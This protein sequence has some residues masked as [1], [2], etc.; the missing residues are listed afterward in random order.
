MS[1]TMESIANTMSTY[2]NKDTITSTLLFI[3]LFFILYF[4]YQA[5][6]QQKY[7]CN[8]IKGY[9]ILQME[10]I[11]LEVM[12]LPIHKTY[13]KTAYNCCCN[14]EFK[15]GYVDKCALMN[16][17]KQ[18]VRA[19]DFT[20]YSLR[21]EPV[22]GTSTLDSKKYKESYNSM[23]FTSTMAQV[24]QLF[25]YDIA[26]C[27]NIKDPLF[28]IFRIQSENLNIYNKMGDT[29]Q[30]LFGYGNAAGNKLFKPAY[31]LPIDQ[32]KVSSFDGKVTILVD[33]TGLNGFENSTLATIT[34]LELGTLTNQIYRESEAFEII[35]SG[36]TPNVNH[37]NVLYPDYNPKSNNYDFYTVGMK[38][39]FQFIGMNFQMNDV[40]LTKYN[41]MFKSSIIKQPV[42]E[43]KN[44]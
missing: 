12:N 21:G 33:I 40:Y 39:Q 19:L 18:G 44:T 14:G 43:P 42:V 22:I 41:E 6:Q 29:L 15:N 11:P 30:S 8:L 7:N 23:P 26:N 2:M 25:M 9:P 20:V 38:Q 35:E 4:I 13:I 17:A 37:L 3:I 31:G 1:G 16:C 34:A 24:K 28:L 10:S 36:I 27:P 5:V 32:E